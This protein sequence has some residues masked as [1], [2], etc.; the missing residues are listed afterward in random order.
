MSP[1]AVQNSK[2]AQSSLLIEITICGPDAFFERYDQT[3][4]LGKG[5][6]DS[7]R[8]LHFL[9]ESSASLPNHTAWGVVKP[10]RKRRATPK[11]VDDTA[12]KTRTTPDSRKESKV[13]ALCE[14]AHQPTIPYKTVPPTF[15]TIHCN[16]LETLER[17]ASDLKFIH[18]SIR[19]G[20][21][22]KIHLDDSRVMTTMIDQTA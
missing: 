9:V 7:R 2:K 1:K 8:F 22:A 11:A 20:K 3:R 5:L 4:R 15:I 17:D 21:Y 18:S 16:A 12:T 13:H 10:R 14:Q 19:E 6:V